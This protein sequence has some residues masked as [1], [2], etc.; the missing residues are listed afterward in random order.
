MSANKQY[1]GLFYKSHGTWVGPYADAVGTKQQITE[2]SKLVKAS[3][4]SKT[5]LRRVKFVK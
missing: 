5:Q 4:K 1:Y 2:V 3:L